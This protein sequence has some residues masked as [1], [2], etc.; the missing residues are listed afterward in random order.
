V[1]E[2]E[3]KVRESLGLVRLAVALAEPA[4]A[5]AKGERRVRI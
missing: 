1:A 3:A 4:D 5:A 2:L